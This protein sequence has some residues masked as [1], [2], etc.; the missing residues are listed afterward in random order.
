[1]TLTESNGT[2]HEVSDSV[3]IQPP[4]IDVTYPDGYDSLHR[5]FST[6]SSTQFKEY[7]W[8]YGDGTPLETGRTQDHTYASSGYFTITLTL[9]LN[10]DST[11]QSQ[12]GIFVGP[13]TRYIQG[14]TVYGSETWYSG[15]TYVV[16]GNI[17][18]AQGATL[19]IESGVTVEMDSVLCVTSTQ[20][21]TGLIDIRA[22]AVRLL[23]RL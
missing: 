13:G 7:T 12:V 4:S 9:T 14:H 21:S 16:Q 18:I 22:R 8:N 3:V 11:I 17:S 5:H 20:L 10:D 2:P 15:G 19:T 1:V 6:P 23:K